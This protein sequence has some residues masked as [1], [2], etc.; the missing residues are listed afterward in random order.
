M[1][2]LLVWESSSAWAQFPP[3]TNTSPG[4]ITGQQQPFFQPDSNLTDSSRLALQEAVKPDTRWLNP[5]RLFMHL[6]HEDSAAYELD[7]L[8]NWDEKDTLDGFVQTLG[9]IGKPYQRFQYGFSDRFFDNNQWHNPIMGRYNAY[10]FDPEHQIR[11]YDTHTPY[12]NI[13][14]LQGRRQTQL[15]G[16][17]ASQNISPFLNITA[18][19]KRRRTL[20]IYRS[21]E[22][23]HRSLYLSGNYHTPDRRYAA[24]TNVVYNELGDNIN[25]GILLSNPIESPPTFNKIETP[26][27]E[28]A[29][30]FIMTRSL[31]L[32]QHFRLFGWKDTVE[33]PHK[34]NLRLQTS[35]EGTYQRFV[36]RSVSASQLESHFIPVYPTLNRDSTF[37]LEGY[38][39][40]RSEVKGSGSYRFQQPGFVLGLQGKVGYRRIGFRKDGN[41]LFQNAVVQEVSQQL[42]LPKAGIRQTFR[43]SRVI[44]NI[45]GPE[46]MLEGGLHVVPRL[47]VDSL[48][49]IDSVYRVKI[50]K[51]TSKKKSQRPAPV[52]IQ[53]PSIDSLA[54]SDSLLREQLL[55]P[56]KEKKVVELDTT[57]S[58]AYQVLPRPAAPVGIHI[59][60]KR[61][62]RNPTIFQRYFQARPVNTFQANTALENYNFLHA[63]ASIHYTGR[64][65]VYKRDTTHA[66][67]IGLKVFFSRAG[68][69]IFYDTAMQVLQ[70]PRGDGLT[71]TGAE[72]S[73]RLRFWRSFY[74]DSRVTFQQ[75]SSPSDPELSRYAN[76]I[77][78]IYG[79]TSIYL[80]K[81]NISIAKRLKTGIDLHFFSSYIGQT[82][83]PLTGEF[84]PTTYQ[85]DE[86]VRAD[87]YFAVQIVKP[88]IYLKIM[89]INEAL[90]PGR[91]GYYTT[92]FYPELE[93]TFVLGVNWTFFD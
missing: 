38:I 15:L 8:L 76:H 57:R 4:G 6:P 25:G 60:A 91:P 29:Q 51:T 50:S 63:R 67:Q 35:V 73:A 24:F 80:D 79:R 62:D 27:I 48:P 5:E 13:D 71:W 59:F 42:E 20:G 87:A 18:Y 12:V 75:S 39:A 72:V 70:A 61:E 41:D 65:R 47:F 30:R 10:A 46:T 17:T 3:V 26:V 92:P 16:I 84:F 21:H 74:W 7:V 64:K 49:R 33:T 93:R 85:I 23:D 83:D 54:P 9:L 66:N 34:L 69:M 19:Y 28:D 88:L 58:L 52:L 86:Y 2:C 68:R 81:S 45:F 90:F 11:Y 77:P 14:Y 82:V 36:D 22:T 31:Y 37:L 44:S 1:L 78:E 53:S 43:V 55:K 56:R 32:D 89:H 40:N